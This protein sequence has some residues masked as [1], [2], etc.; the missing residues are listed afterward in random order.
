MT[1]TAEQSQE[2]FSS[3]LSSVN[4]RW[5]NLR[6]SQSWSPSPSSPSEE[7]NCGSLPERCPPRLQAAT[8][9]SRPPVPVCSPLILSQSVCVWGDV[10]VDWMDPSCVSTVYVLSSFTEGRGFLSAAGSG[11]VPTS[12]LLRS[13][14]SRLKRLVHMALW[15]V[16]GGPRRLLGC[17]PESPT[18]PLE[19]ND[20]RPRKWW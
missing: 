10:D 4:R 5:I 9:P 1:T 8:A 19:F 7:R 6:T 11:R 3:T 13:V 2:Q 17:G 12:P 18:N 16:Q 20:G 14:P 15:D